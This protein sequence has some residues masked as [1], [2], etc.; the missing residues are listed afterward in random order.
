MSDT[1]RSVSAYLEEHPRMTGAL[2]MI[3]LLLTQAGNTAAA[4]MGTNAGP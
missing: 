1:T 4:M 3:L 2:F